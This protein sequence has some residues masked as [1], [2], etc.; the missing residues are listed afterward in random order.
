MGKLKAEGNYLI[1]ESGRNKTL[2]I[3]HETRNS[4]QV[5][6]LTA[7]ANSIILKEHATNK[8]NLHK[9]LPEPK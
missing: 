5:G 7:V 1:H 6:D 8:N 4:G 2:Y 3:T 9:L